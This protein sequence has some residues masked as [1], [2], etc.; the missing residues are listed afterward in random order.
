[1]DYYG[2]N[3]Q[4]IA[5]SNRYTRTPTQLSGYNTP[6]TGMAPAQA[7][8]PPPVVDGR[9]LSQ[10]GGGGEVPGLRNTYSD[11]FSDE[12][13]SLANRAYGAEEYGVGDLALSA[14]KS[15]GKNVARNALVGAPTTAAFGATIAGLPGAAF[16]GIVGRKIAR[17]FGIQGLTKEI[18]GI[19]SQRNLG[20][21][22]D[23]E[24]KQQIMGYI[25]ARDK[26]MGAA[27]SFS[28]EA[29]VSGRLSPAG[30]GNPGAYGGDSGTNSIN[31]SE[32][33]SGLGIGNPAAYTAAIEKDRS[34]KAKGSGY[35][36]YTRQQ[37]EAADRAGF[38]YAPGDFYSSG[39]W[40]AAK[41]RATN[42]EAMDPEQGGYYGADGKWNAAATGRD[43]GERD[44]EG[45][46]TGVGGIGQSA[47]Y[48]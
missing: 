36:G 12:A 3:R 19:I 25:A 47:G 26:D 34:G 6:V 1:M 16:T 4:G 9:E 44:N 11:N 28:P 24:A 17:D 46:G 15:L 2:L 23:D 35:G 31:P 39:N 38:G 45:Y 40:N 37:M 48:K 32:R 29:T 33:L 42:P 14:T 8:T 41:A 20:Y 21:L 13:R 18:Q 30:I 10:V 7:L 22:S 43:Y 27:G 5:A